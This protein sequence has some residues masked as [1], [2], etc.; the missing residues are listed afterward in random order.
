MLQI[1]FL[2]LLVFLTSP[3]SAFW[4]MECRGVAGFARIDPMVSPG[5]PANHMHVFAGSGGLT[6]TTSYADL[7]ASNCTSCMVTQDK[8]SYWQPSLYFFDTTTSQYE[9]V[10][11]VGGM[12]AYYFLNTDDRKSKIMAYPKSFRMIAGDNSR[13]DFTAG[14]YTMVD[15]PK[16]EWA[17]LNQTDQATLAQRA[18]GFNCLNYAKDAEASLLRHFL[19]DK[20]YLD[21]NCPD[22]IR[23][24]LMFPSCWNGVDMDSANHRDH[25]AY[26]DLV[27]EGNCPSSFPVRLP[28]LFYETIWDTP[29]FKDRTGKFVI[30][31]GDVQGFA[32]H[33]DFM[34][35]WDPAFLQEAVNTC[36]SPSGKIGDCP[37]FNIQSLEEAQ[38]CRIAKPA[39]VADDNVRGPAS[40][41]PGKLSTFGK[42]VDATLYPTYNPAYATPLKAT[43]E[44]TAVAG[45]VA[46]GKFVAAP[47]LAATGKSPFVAV[48]P[49][50][51]VTPTV[52]AKS[53]A[54][55]D[56]VLPSM[57]DSS[58]WDIGRHGRRNEQ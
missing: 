19:P 45:A 43:P 40:I 41:L 2:T 53:V 23:F 24:E 9:L 58:R 48:D 16:S 5:V 57:P 29:A 25:V 50:E 49:V 47:A 51:T 35:G 56:K 12:L 46:T 13:R 17:A 1:L 34:S 4:R 42:Y 3:T 52:T 18:T 44:S 7:T 10:Q 32:Y 39:I 21:A 54:A 55:A 27:M 33:G 14:N 26:P 36:T 28:G 11:P 31:N 38:S 20:S 22:G 15:P 37:V 30:A 6:D 8:S